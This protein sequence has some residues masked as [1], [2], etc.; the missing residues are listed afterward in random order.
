MIAL[1]ALAGGGFAAGVCLLIS[2]M[3]LAPARVQRPGRL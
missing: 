2:A 3:W 1:A